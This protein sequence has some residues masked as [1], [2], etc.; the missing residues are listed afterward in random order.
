MAK[1]TIGIDIGGT[2]IKTGL[3]NSSGLLSHKRILSTPALTSTKKTLIAAIIQEIQN[4]LQKKK[5]RKKDVHGIGIGMPGLINVDKGIVYSLTNLPGWRNVPLKQILNKELGMTVWIDN[6][7]NLMALGEW[8][9]GA[10]KGYGDIVCLTLGTG[11]GGGL[12]INN[13]LYRGKG[14]M[15]GEIGH[16]PLSK[17]GPRCNC[18]GRG[19][20]ETFIGNRYLKKRAARLFKKKNISLQEV[21]F[22]AGKGDKKALA[23]WEEVAT[24]LGLALT[25]V[26]NLLNPQLIII[27]GGVAGAYQFM[28][29]TLKETI[30]DRAMSVPAK[31]VKIVRARLKNEAG[32][33]GAY[34][35]VQEKVG[36]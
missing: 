26:V 23:F 21:S 3:F 12:I 24:H 11:V 8:H 6:D 28:I 1:Y 4:L 16:I 34:A 13:Q 35:L 17:N 18:G 7:V 20:L 30:H 33:W 29:R 31:M 32:V 10:G 14:F 5:L 27:G 9:Y 2:N 36:H 22:M 25:G 19:C 15:A